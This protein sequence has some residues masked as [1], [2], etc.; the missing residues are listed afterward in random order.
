MES[1][2]IEQDNT[3]DNTQNSEI[4]IEYVPKIE[5]K[6]IQS[7]L[8]PEI[9]YK[10]IKG[11]HNYVFSKEDF[12]LDEDLIVNPN[13]TLKSIINHLKKNITKDITIQHKDELASIIKNIRYIEIIK[14]VK[15]IDRKVVDKMLEYCEPI[16]KGDSLNENTENKLMDIGYVKANSI[17]TIVKQLIRKLKRRDDVTV[18]FIKLIIYI[19]TKSHNVNKRYTCMKT[20]KIYKKEALEDPERY[21]ATYRSNG[22]RIYDEDM[23]KMYKE[24]METNESTAFGKYIGWLGCRY[25]VPLLETLY[26][27]PWKYTEEITDVMPHGKKAL[28]NIMYDLVRQSDKECAL[29]GLLMYN[30]RAK[31]DKSQS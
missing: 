10:R 5:Y 1:S 21:F 25:Y 14:N 28:N 29:I 22:S 15:M 7:Q 19:C 18:E 9:Q 20:F 23:P 30:I 13:A 27:M 2:H 4:V 3:Q 17:N 26:N 12:D 11:T 24:I 6:I 31:K 16:H 8:Y